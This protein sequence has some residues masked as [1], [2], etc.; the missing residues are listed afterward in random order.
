M[1]IY[2]IADEALKYTVMIRPSL[3][4]YSFHE[5]ETLPSKSTNGRQSR[6]GSWWAEKI[7][8]VQWPRCLMSIC[9]CFIQDASRTK[10]GLLQ[11]LPSEAH[12]GLKLYPLQSMLH[13][14]LLRKTTITG[15]GQR[16]DSQFGKQQKSNSR[17]SHR[18]P[19][20]KAERTMLCHG[21]FFSDLDAR[22]KM[23]LRYGS[24]DIYVTPVRS[25][26]EF[27]FLDQM[28]TTLVKKKQDDSTMERVQESV[29]N[30]R[31]QVVSASSQSLILPTCIIDNRPTPNS[32]DN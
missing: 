1:S 28:S 14:H 21:K 7:L 29:L 9:S 2:T 5:A 26:L 11:E 32:Q 16:K 20:H 31:S 18:L 17:L 6:T 3:K 23:S 30:Q 25:L 15:I 13:T 8:P 10:Q 24:G 19:Q 4:N 27:S 22:I 12:T